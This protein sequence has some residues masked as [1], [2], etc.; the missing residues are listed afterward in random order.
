MTL[1]TIGER[2]APETDLVSALTL[3][4]LPFGLI[5]WAWN[6][7][8]YIARDH[9]LEF[10]FKIFFT[11]FSLFLSKQTGP[12][13]CS[14]MQHFIWVFT[15][16]Q[17]THLIVSRVMVLLLLLLIHCW[18]FLPL[19]GFCFVFSMLI[20]HWFVFILASLS[21]WW[22]RGGA[23]CF[24]LSPLCLVSVIVLW[25]ILTPPWVD[26]KCVSVVF[27]DHTHFFI[28]YIMSETKCDSGKPLSYQFRQWMTDLKR[29]SGLQ[30]LRTK[31]AW[32]LN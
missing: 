6:G 11:L 22:G 4:I 3:W 29:W 15:V 23:G 9:R 21:S 8:F 17:S 16:C 19:W 2:P 10:P 24:T 14:I 20:L 28:Q 32:A 26:L 31:P 27:L 7:S 25:L 18:L 5:Q 13:K 12:E 1:T 30:A